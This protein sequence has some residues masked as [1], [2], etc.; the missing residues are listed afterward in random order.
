M[1]RI[2]LLLLFCVTVGALIFFAR[3]TNVPTCTPASITIQPASQASCQGSTVSF[4]VT[5]SGTT[6][7]SYQWRKNS[8]NL[9]NGG[10]ISGVTTMNLT[11]TNITTTDAASYDVVVANSCGRAT[12]APPATLTMN[13][14]PVIT[15]QPTN[16]TNCQGSTVSFGVAATGSAPLGYQWRK[17]STNLNNGGNISGATTT[18]LTITNITTTD[19]ASYDVVVANSCGRATSAPP[20]TLTV[21][22]PPVI[23]V[24]PTN[25]T[26]CQG[27]TI[28]FA[29]AATGSAPLGYQ[30]RK[31]STNLN[32]GGNI[33]GVTTTN[34]TITNI[35]TADAA[36]STWWSPTIVAV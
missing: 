1:K 28:S 30:W 19:A 36:S 9:N 22:V 15:V 33:S 18:N 6:P 4:T 12:S 25:Q 35:T 17:N 13:V 2:L 3:A 10:N 29:V 21:N 20:A 31:N 11:I 23:T 7:L 32:N 8:T 16:Q 14:P 24:Q 5:A 34:L 27:S 26:N